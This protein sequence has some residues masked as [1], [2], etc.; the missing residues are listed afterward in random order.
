MAWLSLKVIIRIFI[1]CLPYVQCLQ[2]TK[3]ENLRLFNKNHQTQSKKIHSIPFPRTKK[4][5]KKSNADWL[6]SFC[7][8][9]HGKQIYI[10]I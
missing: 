7:F 9:G 2:E 8:Y 1:L 6:P 10:K 4:K 5:K 3:N